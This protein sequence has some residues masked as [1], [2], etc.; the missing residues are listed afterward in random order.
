VATLEFYHVDTP[1]INYLKKYQDYIWNN[2]D[3]DNTRPYVGVLILISGYK[4]YAPLTSPKTVNKKVKDNLTKIRID[5]GNQFMGL[6]NL[7]NMIPVNDDDV[8]LVNFNTLDSKY[9]SL[10]KTQRIE[11]RKKEKKIYQNAKALYNKVTKHAE[12]NEWLVDR[13][14]NFKL[15]EQKCQEYKNSILHLEQS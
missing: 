2:D 12:D 15:L 9:T 8:T 14:Y 1:Y 10:L 7:N 5:H 6:I 4:Y 11:I 13:C 3:K